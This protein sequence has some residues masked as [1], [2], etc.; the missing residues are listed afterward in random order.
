MNILLL[1][2]VLILSGCVAD[3]PVPS[4]FVPDASSI[5]LIVSQKFDE[6]ST[7]Y[8]Y[9]FGARLSFCR[10]DN[11]GFYLIEGNSGFS[12]IYYYFSPAGLSLGSFAQDDMV[13]PNEPTPRFDLD[14]YACTILMD[15]PGEL[16]SQ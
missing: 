3:M 13:Y 14:N 5:P 8:Q 4:H 9:S 10:A 12:K 1:L 7:S 15:R 6:V 2:I 16:S 11:E